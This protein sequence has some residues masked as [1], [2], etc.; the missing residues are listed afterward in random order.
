MAGEKDPF[1][2]AEAQAKQQQQERESEQAQAQG[3]QQQP[4][5]ADFEA[6]DEEVSGKVKGID[7]ASAAGPAA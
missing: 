3:Q 1:R 7:G 4:T 6:Y 5:T 2:A